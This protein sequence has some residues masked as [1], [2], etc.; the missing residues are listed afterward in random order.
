MEGLSKPELATIFGENQVQT[1][2]SGLGDQ[3]PPMT[4]AH[5]HWHG[6][7]RKYSDIPQHLLPCTESLQDT[8][9][10]TKPL[11]NSHILPDLK[12]GRNVMVEAH[13]N[14]L[15]SLIQCIDKLTTV[16]TQVCSLSCC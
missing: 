9:D 6:K 10:R 2:R 12:R 16:Q 7:E 14:S 3:P 11:W 1:W 15:R 13:T 4:E 5:I 8:L